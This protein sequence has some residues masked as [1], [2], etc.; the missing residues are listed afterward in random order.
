MDQDSLIEA[1]FRAFE[2]L[3]DIIID[4]RKILTTK[5]KKREADKIIKN[6][7]KDINKVEYLELWVNIM[8]NKKD[9][10][11][12][13]K[14]DNSNNVSDI[15]SLHNAKSVIEQS[16]KDRKQEIIEENTKAYKLRVIDELIETFSH[17]AHQDKH[18]YHIL[19]ELSKL[20]DYE[21][22]ITIIPMTNSIFCKVIDTYKPQQ[23]LKNCLS[24]DNF[25]E[26]AQFSEKFQFFN[27]TK[28]MLNEFISNPQKDYKNLN[29]IFKEISGVEIVACG[30]VLKK[31]RLWDQTCPKIILNLLNTQHSAPMIVRVTYI[32]ALY[33]RERESP[34]TVSKK[35]DLAI[36]YIPKKN[37]D[38]TLYKLLCEAKRPV[39]SI[40]GDDYD[41]LIR[42]S[43]SSIAT[44]SDCKWGW[45][46]PGLIQHIDKVYD[47]IEQLIEKQNSLD[48]SQVLA[49]HEDGPR[50]VIPP[51]NGITRE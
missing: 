9:V 1:Y 38:V 31:W 18:L 21:H 26:L 6:C 10:S 44:R 39:G 24:V 14:D 11:Q 36:A 5:F 15:N 20:K 8:K 22:Q 50:I 3:N 23:L 25:S 40:N 13:D 30:N 33:S 48:F 29:N 47:E 28:K 19:K 27:I 35:V 46:D 51:E 32:S 49:T 42:W 16:I 41:K 4:L 2:S 43:S 45:T 17:Q 34:Q 37:P 12:S 7:Q